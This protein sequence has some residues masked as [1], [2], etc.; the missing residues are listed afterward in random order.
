MLLVKAINTIEI[1]AEFLSRSVKKIFRNTFRITSN[2]R[3]I[4]FISSL[5][6]LFLITPRFQS[7]TL[8]QFRYLFIQFSIIIKFDLF[9][10]FVPINDIIF[11]DVVIDD[12]LISLPEPSLKKEVVCSRV[13]IVL[14]V[15]Y[16]LV[17]LGCVYVQLLDLLLEFG[18]VGD[19]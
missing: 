8:L 11:G 14:V 17:Q 9:N 5:T 4:F 1:F 16:V 6:P 10:Q 19:C 18:F 13:V 7:S 2:P 15:D 3:M 12:T